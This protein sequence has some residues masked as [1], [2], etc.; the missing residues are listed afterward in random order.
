MRMVMTHALGSASK[1]HVLG[2]RKRTDSDA[3]RGMTAV[4][5]MSH[6]K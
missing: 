6:E 2:C 1:L 5:D 4:S 3:M